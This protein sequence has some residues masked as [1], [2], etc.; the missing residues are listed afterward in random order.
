MAVIEVESEPIELPIEQAVPCGLVMNE[1]VTNSLKHG[2]GA[3]GNP[4]ICVRVGA[5]DGGFYFQ[6]S[7]RGPG[8][9]SFPEGRSSFG[10]TLIEAVARQLRA[11][12]EVS[13]DSGTCVRVTVPGLALLGR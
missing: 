3:D 5:V 6:V 7:D 1:L 12:V 11:T 4:E 10:K 9:K 13:S 2:G 8:M